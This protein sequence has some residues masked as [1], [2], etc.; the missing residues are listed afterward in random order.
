MDTIGIESKV[1]STS[2]AIEFKGSFKNILAKSVSGRIDAV[3]LSLVEKVKLEGV[4]GSVSLTVPEDVTANVKFG[5]VSGK[6]SSTLNSGAKGEKSGEFSIGN[7]E[8]QIDLSTTSGSIS[9]GAGGTSTVL[10][11]I[12]VTKQLPEQ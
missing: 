11:E 10:S 2:G 4:S 9:L 12:K 7:S 5:S 3:T 6:F 1:S 8:N